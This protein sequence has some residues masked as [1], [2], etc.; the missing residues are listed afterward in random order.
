MDTKMK[1]FY[2][3]S[4]VAFSTIT[5]KTEQDTLIFNGYYKVDINVVKIMI[6]CG[7]YFCKHTGYVFRPPTYRYQ[8]ENKGIELTIEIR[9]LFSKK[10]K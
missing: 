10:K 7:Y 9:L 8:A 5:G 2:H 6:G 4:R 1:R 3:D